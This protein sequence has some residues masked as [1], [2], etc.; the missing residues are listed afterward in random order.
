MEHERNGAEGLTEPDESRRQI[1]RATASHGA[2]PCVLFRILLCEPGGV[3][4]DFGLRL[5]ERHAGFQLR[6]ITSG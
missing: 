1:L 5:L 6:A 2:D 3:M 4:L